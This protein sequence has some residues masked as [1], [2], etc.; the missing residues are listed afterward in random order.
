MIDN[1]LDPDWWRNAVVY[2]IYPRS[3]RDANGDGIG[4][5]QGVRSGLP[6]LVNLGID[7]IWLTP[8]YPSPL[9][10]GGYDVTDYR[11][12]D[13]RLGT[14]ED[15][16][17]LVHDA[18]DLG[19]K[20][21]V[22]IVP[23]HCSDQH[24][25]FKQALKEGPDSL[26][27]QRFVF[28]KGKGPDGSLPPTNW[29]SGVGG[30]AWEPCGDGW[31]Y[32]HIFTKEQP[33]FNWE[34]EEV[35]KDFL[36]T[37]TF[38]SDHGVDGFRIDVSHGLAKDLS[39]P[40]RDRP[41]PANPEPMSDKG[42]DP[43]YDRDEVHD[44][45]REWRKVFNRY[46][47]PRMAIGESWTP[48]TE[49]VYDYARPDELGSVFDFSLSKCDWDRREYQ[50]AI[51]RTWNGFRR[52]GSTPSWVLGN[53]DVPRVASRLALPKGADAVDWVASNGT[54]PVIDQTVGEARA[55][56]AGMLLLALP[57]TAYIY[58]GDELGLPEDLE[59]KEEDIQD[60][61]WERSGHKVKGRDGCR[62]PLPWTTSKEYAYG[63]S[64]AEGV[65]PWLPQ[66]DW[67]ANYAVQAED[68]RPK[69]PLELYKKA[70][71]LRCRWVVAE[72][73]TTMKIVEGGDPGVLH[74][75]LSTGLHCLLNFGPGAVGLGID[76]KIILRSNEAC[77]GA[78]KDTL[79]ENACLW[80]VEH[81]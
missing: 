3:F 53:H 5:L 36:K 52:V 22:D 79:P 27:R 24:P 4:D 77:E 48:I 16:D 62:V 2:Q 41:D 80:F 58:Q 28:R 35:R 81:N 21:I 78:Q 55:C 73:G 74:I 54:R 37:L 44:I 65:R 67:F 60:P 12:V 10:D 40:L 43:L 8:F 30:S 66:P 18:H 69:S 29:L 26:M 59:I 6:Y 13:S 57:G 42:D 23:N 19:I 75:R 49:R 14:M 32:L 70:L 9:V 64:A 68:G 15:F 38:W 7:A 39:E 61:S 76:G 45:Y 63:F 50:E 17:A 11:N 71:K 47:P 31:Y 20:V 33:D 34:N 72:G 1:M 51:Q 46:D 25:W 56:A